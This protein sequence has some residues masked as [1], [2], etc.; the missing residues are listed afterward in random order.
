MEGLLDAEGVFAVIAP[1]VYAFCL[2]LTRIAAL[3]TTTPLFNSPTVSSSIKAAIVGI[4][5][6]F[7][8]ITADPTSPDIRLEFFS[9]FGAILTEA[10][11]GGV[12]GLGVL[13]LFAA[14]QF[15]GQLVGIQMGFAIAN[16]VDPTTFQQVGV[17]SQ[18]L[19]VFGLMLFLALDGHLIVLQALF[20]SIQLIPLGTGDPNGP[21][22]ITEMVRY[23][24]KIFSMGLRIGLPVVC[25]VLLV[26]VGLATLA[27]TVPQVNIFILGFLFTISMGMMVLGLA[28]PSTGVV[29]SRFLEE[30]LYDVV[31]MLSFF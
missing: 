25:V 21:L 10:I 1:Y 14:L 18:F 6:I 31:G 3:F 7:V 16:V 23:G 8:M 4:L 2:A 5:T 12:M 20:E 11:I 22:I 13:V 30:A 27:R 17:V 28:L 9:V 19:N 26:N 24:A 15:T 29:F